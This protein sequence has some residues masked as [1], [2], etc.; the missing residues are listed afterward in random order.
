M[1]ILL[2]TLRDKRTEAFNAMGEITGVDA[3][4]YTDE[5]HENVIRLNDEIEKL[6]GQ[7][8]V[9]NRALKDDAEQAEY[10]NVL[11]DDHNMSPDQ[12]QAN[13]ICSESIF[14]NV[15]RFGVQAMS[16]EDVEFVKAAQI[17]NAMD[18][19][20]DVKGGFYIPTEIAKKAI[21]KL[22]DLGGIRS[23]ATIITTGTGNPIS[24]P[25]F[26]DGDNEG[27]L[28][29]TA[30]A[31]T[32]GPDPV[33]GSITLEAFKMS[34]KILAVDESLVQDTGF[35]LINEILT[36]MA[37]RWFR[38]ESRLYTV[39]TGVAQPK[40]IVPSA[41]LGHTTDLPAA[42][43][44]DDLIDLEHSLD[45]VIREMAGVAWSFNDKT[46]KIIKKLKNA[47]GEYIWKGATSAG[48]PATILGYPY[49]IN[50]KMDDV[51]ASKHPIIFGMLSNYYVRDVERKSMK[52]FDNAPEYAKLDQ[53][54]FLGIKRGDGHL[55]DFEGQTVKKMLM[56]A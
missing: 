27:E 2:N 30:D 37:M 8:E 9:L 42:F 52:R 17:Q 56:H 7:I 48:Q 33:A 47:E 21:T 26:D 4:N 43:T 53:I 44:F 10:V 1:T 45:P 13:M 41:A 14:D 12:I 31:A 39:G 34:T 24:F 35:D 16:V 23:Y 55:R 15:L 19:T 28:L 49:H 51:A 32:D 54:A 50:Q 20:T 3:V 18:G 22:H 40:G 36:A 38:L 5:M 46:L 25:T 11:A 29:A 6:D